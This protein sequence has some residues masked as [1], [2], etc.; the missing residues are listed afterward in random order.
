MG[1]SKPMFSV[2]L[3]G[4]I[5][6]YLILM[7]LN[8]IL[9]YGSTVGN[10]WCFVPWLVIYMLVVI[11]LFIGALVIVIFFAFLF[12]FLFPFAFLALL[13]FIGGNILLYW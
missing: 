11:G 9:I 5:I 2:Y 8:V 1:E 12:P 6:G 4:E 3:A 13:P 10:R 7:L